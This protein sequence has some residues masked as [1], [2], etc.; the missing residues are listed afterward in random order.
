MRSEEAKRAK[1]SIDAVQALQLHF[2]PRSVRNYMHPFPNS[3]PITKEFYICI[4]LEKHMNRFL[5]LMYTVNNSYGLFIS[6]V[7][8]RK[9]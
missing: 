6:S 5:I 2:K 4:L 7:L 9:V 3:F 1:G 8:T